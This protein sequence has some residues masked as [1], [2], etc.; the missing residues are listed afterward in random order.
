MRAF[1]WIRGLVAT[2]AF[3]LTAASP[4]HA[5][6]LELEDM[7]SYTG[8]IDAFTGE[9]AEVTTPYGT[10]TVESSRSAIANGIYYDKDTRMYIY[11]VGS[12]VSEISASVMDGMVCTGA[13]QIDVP[14][15]VVMELYRNGSQVEFTGNN[16]V[17][18]TGEYTVVVG[19]EGSTQ[20]LF[21]FTLVGEKTGLIS[22]YTMPAGFR[23]TDAMLNGEYAPW[24]RSYISLAEEGYYAITYECERTEVVYNL[25]ITI[26]HTAPELTFE[27]VEEDG[28]ARGAVTVLGAEQTDQVTV[29]KDG[30]RITFLNNKLTQSGR[31]EVVAV[32]DADNMSTYQFTIMI[33]VDS[34]GILFFLFVVA[35]IAA[36]VTYLVLKRKK[37][38]IR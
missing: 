31:Y 2:A 28:R 8:E 19:D 27:G 6:A 18:E 13:V 26:D 36:I 20:S 9:P 14:E 3:V 34:H 15:G 1:G 16:L 10:T 11:P 37:L 21:S 7:T 25:N 17:R 12:G 30:S 35:V 5:G 23:I 22:G 29:Y 33:Y 32:D 24:S 38:R 4:L